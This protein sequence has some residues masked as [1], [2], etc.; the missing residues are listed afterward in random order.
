MK[1]DRQFSKVAIGGTF[2]I[3]HDGHKHVLRM[4]F[5][6]GERVGIGVS[7]DRLAAQIKGRPISPLEERV[8]VLREFLHGE[9]LLDRAEIVILEE[10]LGPVVHDP[11]YDAI[12]VSHDNYQSALTI[13]RERLS[14][15]LKPLEIIVFDKVLAEDGKPISSARIRLGMI[16]REGKLK[17]KSL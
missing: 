4:A 12:L 1:S 17:F 2:D 11:S 14:R 5:Q 16:D 13:N 9:G 15:G 6:L 10:R 7:S 3:L 8:R